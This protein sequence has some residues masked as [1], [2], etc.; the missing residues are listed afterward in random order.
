MPKSK[1]GSS[2]MPNV[3]ENFFLPLRASFTVPQSSDPAGFS[4]DLQEY[5]AGYTD[6]QLV[7]AVS[8]LKRNRTQRTFPTIAECRQACE[9]FSA[10]PKPQGAGK[11]SPDMERSGAIRQEQRDRD[12]AALCRT[13][14]FARAA[15]REGWLT[16]LLEFAEDELREPTEFELRRLKAKAEATDTNLRA[17]MK[18]RAAERVWG[19][20]ERQPTGELVTGRAAPMPRKGTRPGHPPEGMTEEQMRQ[21]HLEK[22]KGMAAQARRVMSDADL[23]GIPDA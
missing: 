3:I 1:E 23:A 15:H 18:A 12:G 11:F 6:Y 9:R 17:A 13:W 22:L 16:T 7:Q 10:A 8:Y 21:W 5:L 4:A 14:P 2:R 20:Q 19:V